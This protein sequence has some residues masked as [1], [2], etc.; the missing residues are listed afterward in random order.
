MRDKLVILLVVVLLFIP[1]A[2]HPAIAQTCTP[3]MSFVADVT[4]P[5]DT[6]MK[7]N[8]SFEKVWRLK[9]SGTCDWR[10]FNV[11]HVGGELMGVTSPQPITDTVKAGVTVDLSVSMK[12][13]DK[14][15]T[16]TSWWQ[17]QDRSGQSVGDKFYVRTVVGRAEKERIGPDTSKM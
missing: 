9:N 15:G 7:P 8:E 14:D 5:D 6:T 1:T 3:G 4:I 2:A 17:V 12:A 10:R 13:A 16:Y 11:A